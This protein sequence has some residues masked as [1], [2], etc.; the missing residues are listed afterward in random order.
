MN[1]LT[2]LGADSNFQTSVVLQLEF[3]ACHRLCFGYSC[4]EGTWWRSWFRHCA[5]RRQVAG[6][7]PGGDTGIFKCHKSY[8]QP[9]GH[10]EDSVS[11]RNEHQEYFLSRV[12]VASPCG[13][14]PFY[15]HA[16]IILKSGSH[17][18]LEPSGLVQACTGVDL[19]LL[20]YLSC[21]S[22]VSPAKFRG[23]VLNEGTSSHKS[24][25]AVYTNLLTTTLKLN[26]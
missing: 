16:P 1:T 25:T 15:F 8:R 23:H 14:Q 20:Y 6:S 5:R 19:L 13:W 10:G 18:D 22:N 17:D 9:D 26:R 12:K 2:L 11:N 3:R 4:S 7:I 24:V 21:F